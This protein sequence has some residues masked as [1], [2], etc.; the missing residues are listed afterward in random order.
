MP[1]GRGDAESADR[2][3]LNAGP[4]G[5]RGCGEL[6]QEFLPGLQANEVIQKSRA[7]HD[8]ESGEE[9]ANCRLILAQCRT[10]AA[11]EEGRQGNRTEARSEDGDAP[12]PWDRMGV[13][14]APIVGPID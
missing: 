5:Q 12:D 13:D 8:S 14:L 11:G 4:A 9:V 10:H 6:A 1:P 3:D 2:M 7:K